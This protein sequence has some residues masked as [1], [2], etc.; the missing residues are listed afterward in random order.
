MCVCV[1]M[2]VCARARS[3]MDHYCNTICL[4]YIQNAG[5][6]RI[7]K[8]QTGAGLDR[9]MLHRFCLHLDSVFMDRFLIGQLQAH[10][11]HIPTPTLGAGATHARRRACM[12]LYAHKHAGKAG[13]GRKSGKFFLDEKRFRWRDGKILKKTFTNFIISRQMFV[14]VC[15]CVCVCQD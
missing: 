9:V 11:K 5:W 2:C 15:V 14:C 3:F 12:H 1:C 7:T 10:T 13:S 4:A 6:A 8:K